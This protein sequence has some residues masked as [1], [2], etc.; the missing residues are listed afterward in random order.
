[1]CNLNIIRCVVT[2]NR[3]ILN[4]KFKIQSVAGRVVKQYWPCAQSLHKLLFWIRLAKALAIVGIIEPGETE[5]STLLLPDPCHWLLNPVPSHCKVGI[6]VLSWFI[7]HAKSHS[8]NHYTGNIGCYLTDPSRTHPT[9]LAPIM[10]DPTLR[11][12]PD[13]TPWTSPCHI[14]HH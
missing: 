7:P 9:Q 2:G 6:C 4:N 13:L 12:T 1:M 8:F 14:H 5:E 3:P 11:P 10:A